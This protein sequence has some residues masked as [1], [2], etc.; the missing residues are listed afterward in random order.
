MDRRAKLHVRIVQVPRRFDVLAEKRVNVISLIKYLIEL[1]L[2]MLYYRTR[3][4]PKVFENIL[5][6]ILHSGPLPDI[7]VSR[8]VSRV[9]WGITVPDDESQTIY[10][11]LDAL[12]NYLTCAGYPNESVNE[13]SIFH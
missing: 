6:D 12:V 2:T 1:L 9:H 11:W 8:P 5:L 13:W 10:V 3:I 4:K 7:S